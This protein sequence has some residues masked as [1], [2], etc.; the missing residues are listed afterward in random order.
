MKRLKE[1]KRSENF[2]NKTKKSFTLKKLK[3][4]E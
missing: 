4:L 1:I 3:M 2:L